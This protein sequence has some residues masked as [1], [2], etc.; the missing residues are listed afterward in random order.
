MYWCSCFYKKWL[1]VYFKC[2]GLTLTLLKCWC[3]YVHWRL[4]LEL[5]ADSAMFF[6]QV[7]LKTLN[8]S[9]GWSVKFCMNFFLFVLKLSMSPQLD[10]VCKYNCWLIIN[11]DLWHLALGMW[12][13]NASASF[14]KSMQEKSILKLLPNISCGVIEVEDL[15]PWV[16]LHICCL[17]G[18]TR[19]QV[20]WTYITRK[21]CPLWS[22]PMIRL[23]FI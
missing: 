4:D 1:E 2:N 14:H 13:I 6:L 10:N 20:N 5:Y 22:W 19:S 23:Y 21:P 15:S 3:H 9:I 18:Q 7:K 11:E 17:S 8:M 12:T 16:E